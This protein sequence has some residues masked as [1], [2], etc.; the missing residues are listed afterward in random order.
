MV[1]ATIRKWVPFGR[2]GT[3]TEATR[4]SLDTEPITRGPRVRTPPPPSASLANPTWA[5]RAI[6]Q[7]IFILEP[8]DQAKP[9]PG[10]EQGRRSASG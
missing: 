2:T 9:A 10:R 4:R 7:L 6:R 3:A 5:R 1:A 8:S